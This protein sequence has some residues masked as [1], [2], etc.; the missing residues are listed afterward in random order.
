M[1][2]PTFY[3][4]HGADDLAIDEAVEKLRAGMGENGDLNTSEFDGS[5]ASAAEVVNAASSYPFLA[6]KRLVIVRGMLAH[7]TRRNAGEA[8]KKQV[9]Y[10]LDALPGLPDYARLVFVER[11]DLPEK[12][13]V[14]ALG[15]KAA[16]GHVK[17]FNVPKDMAAWIM[18]RAKDAYAVVIQPAAAAALAEVTAGDLRR[19]DNELFK[20]SCYIRP[21]EPITEADVA[22]LTPYVAEANLWKMVDAIADGRGQLALH[23]MHRLLEQDRNNT[24]FSLYGAITRQFRMLLLAR[25]HLDGGGS[26]SQLPSVLGAAPYTAQTVA[27]QS[28]AFSVEDL[29]AIHRVLLDYDHQMKTGGI[30]PELALDLLVTSIAR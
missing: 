5:S 11:G 6:D 13:K 12:D 8:G 22:A 29:E 17:Q 16:N 2:T 3:I 20:L 7:V 21:G 23:L 1:A 18:R 27:R 28:R 4:F 14:L 15:Q 24:P 9:E 30:T 19:A 25:E 10:L 26:P